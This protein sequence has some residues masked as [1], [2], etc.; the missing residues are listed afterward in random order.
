MVAGLTLRSLTMAESRTGEQIAQPEFEAF[1]LR[2]ARMLHGYLCRLSRDS[3]TADETLQEAYIRMINAPRMEEEAR[4]AYLYRTATNLL[5]DRWRK[6][7]VERRF[8]ETEDFSESIHENVG[9]SLDVSS[10]F[11][12]LSAVDRAVLWLAH[13]EQLSHREVA[14]ILELKEK[15]IKVMLFRARERARKL[16]VEAG[17]GVSR[18][19]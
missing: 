6:E 17:L 9:L 13:V 19:E 15:S 7:K 14:A 3:A 11:E 5:R 4:K 12:K 10:L 1:Y 18:D 8:W 2:T 16:F